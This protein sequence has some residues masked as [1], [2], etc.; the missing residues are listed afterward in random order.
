MRDE[1]ITLMRDYC[2]KQAELD[3][4][5]IQR[6]NWAK[7]RDALGEGNVDD[8]LQYNIKLCTAVIEQIFDNIELIKRCLA[9]YRKGEN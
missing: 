9:S 5:M 7:Q 1:E 4:A 8:D 2:L 3:A 6:Q